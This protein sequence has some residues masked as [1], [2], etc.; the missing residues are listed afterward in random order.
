MY[1]I[2]T[3]KAF[4]AK[5]MPIGETNRMY[6][7][8][9]EDLGFIRASAQGVRLGRS[10]LKGHLSDFSL[11][12]ISLVKG[13]EIWRI[14]SVETVSQVPFRKNLAKL[15]VLK[16][17][18]SLLVR[19]LH[20][21]EKNQNLFQV[22]AEVYDF[23]S[24]H[25]SNLEELKNLEA[26]AVLRILYHLGYFSQTDD[27]AL[28]VKPISSEFLVDFAPKRAK[29]IRDINAALAETNL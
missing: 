19:L 10:K 25:E 12:K 17:L 20:G 1:H 13:K 15:S 16:N 29:M 23:L 9:T 27:E 24:E 6:L 7:L 21:E 28:L 22:L 11:V 26:V 4:I 14:I 5:N 8:L 18:F 3:T 2:Y